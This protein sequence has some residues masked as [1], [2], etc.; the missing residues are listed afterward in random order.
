M[1]NVLM[2]TSNILNKHNKNINP[3]QITEAVR[4]VAHHLNEEQLKFAVHT[5]SQH[6]LFGTLNK[7]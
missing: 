1:L 7:K 4:I 3:D 6:Q 5:L 2:A